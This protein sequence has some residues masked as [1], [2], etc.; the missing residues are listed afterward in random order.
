[1]ATTHPSLE[2]SKQTLTVLSP[3]RKPATHA[4]RG[5]VLAVH[6]AASLADSV[7]RDAARL[8]RAA[9]GM[10]RAAV[11][12]LEA[13]VKRS[14]GVGLRESTRGAKGP[15]AGAC[16]NPGTENSA[17]AVGTGSEVNL[18][19][20][21][22]EKRVTKRRK[23]NRKKNK[24]GEKKGETNTEKKSGK[25]KEKT[26]TT[27]VVSVPVSEMDLDDGW[28]DKAGGAKAPTLQAKATSPPAPVASAATPTVEPDVTAEV[29][30]LGAEDSILK[31]GMTVT[32]VNFPYLADLNG[33]TGV[34]TGSP[35]S[36]P[37]SQAGRW[38]CTMSSGTMRGHE[39]ALPPEHLKPVLELS[40]P[41]KR[42]SA[43]GP[44]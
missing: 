32:V 16:H 24:K 13:T 31:L 11:A 30:G 43:H 25:G 23:R 22:L 2:R 6:A 42:N 18:P 17:P 15:E 35:D 40:E 9:E 26:G 29:I 28:A 10:A 8:L 12:L 5:T 36:M 44:Y 33:Y 20:A 4:A 19:A 14:P 37:P 34:L 39:F 3:L 38:N 7:D 21:Q 1:M 41:P 27:P